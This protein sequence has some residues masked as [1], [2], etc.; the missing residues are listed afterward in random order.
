M[1][2][3][4]QIAEL[5]AELNDEEDDEGDAPD[6]AKPAPFGLEVP[7]FMLGGGERLSKEAL[8]RSVPPRAVADRL[9]W[10]WFNSPDPGLPSIHKPTFLLE[11]AAVYEN[12]AETH[13]MWLAILFAILSVGTRLASFA[14]TPGDSVLE[15]HTDM[16]ADR[17]QQLAA[18]A[19]SLGDFTKAKK[20]TLEALMFYAGCEYMKPDDHIVRLWL[21]MGCVVRTALRMGYHRD[22]SHYPSITPFEGEMRRR[23][24]QLARVFDVLTSFQLALPSITMTV[25]SDT[26]RPRNLLDS[27]FGPDTVE[28]PPSRPLTEMSPVSFPIAKH[29]LVMV[30]AKAAE[31][32]HRI[33]PLDYESVMEVDQRLREVRDAIP[34]ILQFSSMSQAFLDPPVVVYNRFKFEMLYQKTRCVLHRRYLTE[35]LSDPRGDYSRKAC[36]DAALKLLEHHT[37]LFD[38]SQDPSQLNSTR[39]FLAS[40]NAH[41][42]LLSSMVICLELNLISKA[43]STAEAPGK[44]DEAKVEEMKRV[45]LKSY[46]IYKNTMKHSPDATK[47]VKA[48]EI[49][50]EKVGHLPKEEP[51]FQLPIILGNGALTGAFS[52]APDILPNVDT[53]P[54]GS[55]SLPQFEPIG[56]MFDTGQNADWVSRRPRQ[57]RTSM[58]TNLQSKCGTTSSRRVGARSTRTSLF[59]L[60]ISCRRRARSQAISI[61]RS[62]PLW[63]RKMA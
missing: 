31:I 12:P 36:V 63:T 26:R 34:Q 62:W 30:L 15:Q 4:P 56:D 14:T 47:A 42:F 20:Y 52:I 16:S 29:D 11:Y 50:L 39:W 61:R 5:K 17:F 40:L 23:V 22:P 3:T 8:I 54:M 55:N 9:L 60:L 13:V 38:A 1:L 44:P 43:S 28:L 51:E 19:L 53:L 7:F 32:S 18:C 33:Q 27:D 58:L 25:E 10:H 57:F 59:R 21:F 41:D 49:M 24:W 37:S 45:L 2:T 46:M 35:S 48:M 6:S